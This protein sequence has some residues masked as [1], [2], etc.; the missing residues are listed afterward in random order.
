LAS[1]FVALVAWTALA[2]GFRATL[3]MRQ[4]SPELEQLRAVHRE[5]ARAESE[6]RR[7][8]S[9]IDGV[10]RFRSARGG[11]TLLLG[12]IARIL[13]ES[14]A[15]VTLRLDT[16]EGHFVALTTRAADVVPGLLTLDRSVAARMV[17]SVTMEVVNNVRLQRATFR[18]RRSRPFQSTGAQRRAESGPRAK[19][20]P[21]TSP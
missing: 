7:V 11:I 13:P 8:S 10:S 5:T 21:T 16:L 2:A 4:R 19:R 17:G 15:M 3:L 18:F 12:D 6:L 14:T 9:L 1:T 20:A